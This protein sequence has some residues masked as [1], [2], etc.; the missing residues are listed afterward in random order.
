MSTPLRRVLTTV[1]VVWSCPVMWQ[2][3]TRD[4]TCAELLTK[5]ASPTPL[6][7]SSYSV[8]I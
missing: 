8:N 2:H 6:S 4:S 3:Q 1:F 5:A 7:G